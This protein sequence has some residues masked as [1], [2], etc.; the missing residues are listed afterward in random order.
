MGTCEARGGERNYKKNKNE[1]PIGET[2]LNRTGCGGREVEVS[3]N[4]VK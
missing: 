4:A 1:K 2:P 3:P